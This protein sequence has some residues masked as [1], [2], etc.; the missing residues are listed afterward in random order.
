MRS[1]LDELFYGNIIK[2]VNA[3]QFKHKRNKKIYLTVEIYKSGEPKLAAFIN[4]ISF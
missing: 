4:Y 3:V 2:N 1:I